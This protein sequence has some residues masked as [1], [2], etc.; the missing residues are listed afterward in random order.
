MAKLII[1]KDPSTKLSTKLDDSICERLWRY[2]R[3][4][5]GKKE[6]AVESWHF[7][8]EQIFDGFLKS[9]GC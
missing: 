6:S 2:E 1:E 9:K 8:I 3:E 4:W 7:L 5:R